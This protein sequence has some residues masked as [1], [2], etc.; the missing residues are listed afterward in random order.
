M[1]SLTKGGA[2]ALAHRIE[3][4]WRSKGHPEVRCMIEPIFGVAVSGSTP[5]AVRSNMVNGLPP[6]GAQ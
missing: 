2:A 4:F 3:G 1:D 5:W 6:R